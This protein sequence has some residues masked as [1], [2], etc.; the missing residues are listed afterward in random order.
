MALGTPVPAACPVPKIAQ[1]LLGALARLSP[2]AVPDLDVT[3][4]P[5]TTAPGWGHGWGPL[6][7]NSNSNSP[8]VPKGEQRHSWGAGW[9][10]GAPH[11][12][13][14]SAAVRLHDSISE[15]GHHY[16]IFDL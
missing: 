16:L 3:F 2:G 11:N 12:P 6:V 7:S 13:S 5:R 15:E 4:E 9:E 14:V 1:Q 8:A 10:P